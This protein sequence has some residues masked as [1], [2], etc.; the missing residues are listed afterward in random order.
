MKRYGM[1]IRIKPGFEE[2]Y[3]KYHEAVW[4]EVLD[5]I[6]SCHISNYSIFPK[7]SMLY[8]YFEYAGDDLR[9]IWRKW[10]LMAKRRIG[11]P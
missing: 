7:D 6:R 5:M 3:R 9:P 2:A 10:R 4:P 8:S 1:T 11:G